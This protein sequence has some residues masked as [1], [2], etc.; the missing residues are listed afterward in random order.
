MFPTEYELLTW[1]IIPW[2]DRISREELL[3]LRIRQLEQRDEDI[4]AATERVKVARM[5]NKDRFDATHCIRKKRL[6]PGDWVI[7]R[8]SALDGTKSTLRKFEKRWFGPYVIQNINENGTYQLREL[9]GTPIATLIAGT[10]VKEFVRRSSKWTDDHSE[11]IIDD[12]DES[13]ALDG[14]IAGSEWR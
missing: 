14:P 3:V 2:E 13:L 10:R 8:N 12:I 7:V 6:E 11:V 4:V 1:S 9:D 5:R